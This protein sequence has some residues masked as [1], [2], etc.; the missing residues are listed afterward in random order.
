M[1]RVAYPQSGV[2]MKGDGSAIAAPLATVVLAPLTRIGLDTSAR[3]WFNG[4]KDGRH[5]AS[6][7]L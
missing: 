1:L 5:I 4:E 3:Q 7:S 6:T 2:S